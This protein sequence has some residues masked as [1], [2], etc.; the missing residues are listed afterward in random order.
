MDT[1]VAPE[2]RAF[3]SSSRRNEEG[4]V[5]SWSEERSAREVVGRTRMEPVTTGCSR[6]SFAKGS[7]AEDD[8]ATEAAGAAAGAGWMESPV[9]CSA[10]PSSSGGMLDVCT[11]SCACCGDVAAV[12]TASLMAAHNLV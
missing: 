4:E 8:E 2:S 5:R 7:R 9:F 6:V 12:S 11:G 10:T 1:V 3:S